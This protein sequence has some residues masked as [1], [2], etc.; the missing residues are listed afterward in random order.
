MSLAKEDDLDA[1]A[2]ERAEDVFESA[3]QIAAEY[4]IEIATAVALGKPAQKIVE[5]ASEFDIV[6][7][8]SH[9]R[10][11]VDRMLFGNVAETVARRA[12]IPV[13]IVR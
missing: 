6:V 2:E 7:L 13:A 1:A 8:G 3:R 10:D 11:L 4:D 9:G 5:R 12:P